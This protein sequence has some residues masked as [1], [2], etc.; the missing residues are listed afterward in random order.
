MT[1]V[2]N[3]TSTS[4]SAPAV[5]GDDGDTGIFFPTANVLAFATAGTEDGRFDASGNFLVGTTGQ[6]YGNAGNIQS[7]GTANFVAGGNAGSGTCTAL[8]LINNNSGV[9]VGTVTYTNLGTSYTGVNGITFTATQNTSADANTLDDYEEGTF[10]PSYTSAGISAVTYGTGRNGYY[11]KIGR[12]VTIVVNIMTDAVTVTNGSSFVFITGLPFTAAAL[13]ELNSTTGI[14][15]TSRFN[16][17][18]PTGGVIGNNSTQYTLYRTVN[19]TADDPVQSTA[20]DFKTGA[21]NV[22]TLRFTATYF[23]AT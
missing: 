7:F 1:T 14:T 20:S 21:G 16:A 15:L 11:T 17:N 13:T 5:V 18:P 6:I 22:N 4:A 8:R 10:T 23:T 12:M 9:T 3:G 2:I 19:T